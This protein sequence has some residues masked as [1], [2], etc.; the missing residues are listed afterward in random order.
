[1]LTLFSHMR[2]GRIGRQLNSERVVN[3]PKNWGKREGI[4][5]GWEGMIITIE[6]VI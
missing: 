5:G 1:M 2:E 3:L 6:D 4:R